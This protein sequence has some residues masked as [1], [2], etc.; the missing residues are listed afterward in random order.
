MS[1]EAE[2]FVI[3]YFNEIQKIRNLRKY[4]QEAFPQK[5]Q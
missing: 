3:F 1:T 4:V 2:K 5:H